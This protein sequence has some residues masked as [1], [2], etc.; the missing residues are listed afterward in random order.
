MSTEGNTPD[1]SVDSDAQVRKVPASDPGTQQDLLGQQDSTADLDPDV[2]PEP[3]DQTAP[4]AADDA[5]DTELSNT[6]IKPENG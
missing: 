6:L 5:D 2:Q 3:C 4:E 1:Q